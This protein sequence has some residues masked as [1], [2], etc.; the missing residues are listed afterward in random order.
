MNMVDLELFKPCINC[1]HFKNDHFYTFVN[2]NGHHPC[3]KC[4]C[5]RFE[6]L[7]K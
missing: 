7:N 5:N 2:K 1:Y 6:E 3:I 4:N